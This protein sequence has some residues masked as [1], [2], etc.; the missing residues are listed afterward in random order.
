MN[1]TFYLFLI[2]CIASGTTWLALY[3]LKNCFQKWKKKKKKK[4]TLGWPL[5]TSENFYQ[6]IK[7]HPSFSEYELTNIIIELSGYTK[8]RVDIIDLI[9]VTRANLPGS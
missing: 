1:D 4:S 5:N 8:V 7:G 6:Y 3:A 9:R 2:A